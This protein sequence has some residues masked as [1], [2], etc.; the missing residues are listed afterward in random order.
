MNGTLLDMLTSSTEAT[1][2]QEDPF[3]AYGEDLCVTERLVVSPLVGVFQPTQSEPAGSRIGVGT[4][5]GSVA[6][7]PVRSPFGGRLMGILAHPGE[8]IRSGQPV[9]WLQTEHP[10]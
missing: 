4:V 5:L 6:G 2:L 9:A 10:Q 1:R 3:E 7:H 8:R